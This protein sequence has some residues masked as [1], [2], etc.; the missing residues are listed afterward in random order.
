MFTK[1]IETASLRGVITEKCRSDSNGAGSLNMHPEYKRSLR[2]CQQKT[3]IPGDSLARAFSFLVI[4]KVIGRIGRFKLFFLNFF[5][6]IDTQRVLI[7][8][9]P[10]PQ[11]GSGTF[12]PK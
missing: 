4:V 10:K 8:Y 12:K 6:F 2:R 9:F 11:P 3:V 7:L 1:L 5:S